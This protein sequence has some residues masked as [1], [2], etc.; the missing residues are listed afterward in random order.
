MTARR[1]SASVA[2]LALICL[3]C[4]T[5]IAIETVSSAGPRLARARG[6]FVDGAVLSYKGESSTTEAELWSALE[7]ELGRK[8]KPV[9]L[10]PEREQSDLGLYFEQADY[11]ACFSCPQSDQRWYWWGL[12]LDGR[13]RELA[14]L[15]GEVG[16]E[17][18]APY[19]SFV[20]EVRR[21][22]RRSRRSFPE[23]GHSNREERP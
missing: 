6:V 22:V 3:G 21:L 17:G 18:R 12:I 20:K 11:L 1:W 15:H 8:K 16:K 13:G 5:P 23:A 10:M 4:A 19:L 2:L 9:R 14:S 7:R